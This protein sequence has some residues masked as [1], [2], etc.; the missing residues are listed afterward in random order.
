MK[1][2]SEYKHNLA[3]EPALELGCNNSLKTTDMCGFQQVFSLKEGIANKWISF[4]KQKME[5]PIY[6]IVLCIIKEYCHT[7]SK[8]I[9]IPELKVYLYSLI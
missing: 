4:A 1:R 3:G 6:G 2:M 7:S 8:N 9:H 5:L